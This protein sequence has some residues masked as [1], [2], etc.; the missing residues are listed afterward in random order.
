MPIKTGWCIMTFQKRFIKARKTVIEND[1]KFLNDMQ[2]KAVLT[3]EGPLLLLAGAGSGKTTVL[4]NRIANLVKYGRGSDSDEIPTNVSED[5]LE[6]LEKFAESPSPENY[7]RAYGLT[8]LD[9]V[10]PWRIIAITFTNKAAEELK[11]RLEKMLGSSALD[12]WAST[13]HS[14][15]VKILRRDIESFGFSR[16]FTIYDTTD[17][18]TVMKKI[19][20]EFDLDDKTFSHRMVL[21]QIS[22][23]KDAMISPEQF[24]NEAQ[25]KNDFRKQKIGELYVEYDK[26]LKSANALDF[27]DL[28]LYTVKL[29]LNNTKVREYYQNKFKY[30]LI[31]EYQDTNNLQYLLASALAG[32]WRNICVVGDDDQSIYKFR[33]ATIKNILDFENQYQD[34]RVIRLEQNYRSTANILG[35]ANSVISN[36]IGRKGK[37]LWTENT[38]GEAL[39]LYTASN[40][41]DEAQYVAS[42]IL[43]GF[44]RGE[45][46]RDFAVL[47]RMNAQSNQLEYAFKRNAIPYKVVGGTRFFDRA[48]IKDVLA[49]LCVINNPDDSLRL[50]RIINVPARAIG[51]KTIEDIERI[52]KF[53]NITVYEAVKNASIYPDLQK[54]SMKLRLFAD[55][56]EGLRSA[57]ETMPLDEFYDLVLE[58]SGY[59]RMLEEKDIIENISRIENIRELKTNII[60]FLKEREGGTLSEF[61]DEIAL[62]TDMD[63][64]EENADSVVMMTMHSAKGLEFPTVF[65]VGAE[66]GIF[67][68]SASSTDPE[69]LEEERRLCYV[70]LTRAKSRLHLTNAHHRML[71]G[72]TSANRLSRFVDEIPESYIDKPRP[73]SVY[74]YGGFEQKPTQNQTNTFGYKD[75][76][77]APSIQAPP[78]QATVFNFKKGDTVMHKA[79]GKGVVVSMQMMGGDA[80]MEVAFES[81]GTKRLMRNTAGK[82]MTVLND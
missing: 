58:K 57:A 35:A 40:E 75:T 3:T 12:I 60:S 78:Q 56:I 81:S 20:K 27:D 7:E 23:A 11:A 54:S 39:C 48:E 10:E 28:I 30:V 9:P 51:S 67:P 65:I 34:A 41:G 33:G 61:L 50:L 74:S 38:N 77:K 59:L 32:K 73:K 46:W 19:I 82:Q 49:Y 44:S 43:E 79:F 8:V 29:L 76:P 64:Y 13:F 24:L 53:E 36:N 62:Y 80:L 55:L 47:Y 4:I 42:K 6:F 69:E 70:A 45:N 63:Q 18:N 26:R 16:S 17:S 52:A 1:F 2:K 71:F 15:C 72:R 37:E 5:D 31:D 22:K 68:G 21:S 14:A 25:K 66:E